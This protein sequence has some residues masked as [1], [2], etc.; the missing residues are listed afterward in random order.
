MYQAIFFPAEGLKWAR[1]ACWKIKR[2]DGS[3]FKASFNSFYEVVELILV[4][5]E[6]L[7]DEEE[8]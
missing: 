1:I 8:Y 6:S 7:E 4:L 2:P 5:N 3:F